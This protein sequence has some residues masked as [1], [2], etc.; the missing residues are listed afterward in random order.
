[1]L[2]EIERKTY[3]QSKSSQSNK[4]KTRRNGSSFRQE[5]NGSIICGQI[6]DQKEITNSVRDC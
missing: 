4:I 5:K 1:M 6:G 3:I 2:T